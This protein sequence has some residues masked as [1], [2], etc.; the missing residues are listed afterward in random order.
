MDSSY[1]ID[2]IIFIIDTL[3]SLYILAIMLRFLL[4]W[5]NAD[6]YNPY[7]EFIVKVTHP[8]IKVLR[9]YIP[10]I[11][12][13]DTSCLVF[14]MILQIIAAFSIFTLMGTSP[15]FAALTV[16]ALK[17]LLTMVINIFVF[18][19]LARAILSWVAPGSYNAGVSI[20]F[21]LTEP[22]LS[23]SRKLVPVISGIDLSPLIAL[24]G[25]QLAKMFIVPPLDQLMRLIG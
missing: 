20:L 18:A 13:I 23:L 3:F 25:L 17:Q 16:Y 6:F 14:A 8:P 10:A 22:V 5:V 12:K 9:R 15:T 4:Q 1:F 19:I 24:I 2:P 11:G 21:S 7:S